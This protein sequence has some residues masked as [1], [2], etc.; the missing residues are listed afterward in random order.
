MIDI[1]TKIK[2]NS[3]NEIPQFGFGVWQ[4]EDGQE[5]KQAILWALEAGYRHIDTAA[6]YG[7][8][9]SVGDAVIAGGLPREELF[10][11]TKLWN[12]DVRRGNTARAFE[13]SMEKLQMDYVDLYLIHWPVDGFE[14]AWKD[15][16]KIY[17]SGRAKA[18]GLSNFRV[19]HLEKILKI[20]EVT[21]AAN[22]M[23]FNPQMQDNAI[24]DMCREKGIVFEAWSPLGSGKLAADKMEAAAAI[25]RKYGKSPQQA[26]LRWIL[27]KGIVVFPKSVNKDRI[28][29]NADIFDF[30]LS[31]ADM[32]VFD[33]MNENKRVGPDP[34]H[35]DF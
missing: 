9:R 10:I 30:E 13:E 5:A 18:I 1:N 7:N 35:V 26:I 3:G 12:E 25:G 24:L 2:L 19:H 15:M 11:T 32:A 29:Q 6:I 27:Q 34:D 16:E 4:A 33:A 21:P 17:R 8:E 22:Q 20:C 14:Q 28:A 31:V 23:E